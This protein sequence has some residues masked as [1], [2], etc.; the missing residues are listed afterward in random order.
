MSEIDEWDKNQLLNLEKEALGF[1]ITGHP[2][3]G[4]EDLLEKFTNADTLS[5]KERTDRET[6]RIG[7]IIRAI[8]TIK[9][10]KGDL[11]AF[12]T[13]EDLLGAV[14]V[15]VFPSTYTSVCGLLV[16]DSAILIQGQMQKDENAVK[17][18][19]DS[20]IAMDK[21]EENWTA[22]VHFNLNLERT[23]RGILE[24]LHDIL[25]RHP[26]SCQAFIHLREDENNE[27]V[28]ELPDSLTVK[29]GVA[30]TCDVQELL[31]YPAVETVCS[32][33]PAEPAPNNS[34]TNHNRRNAQYA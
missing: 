3:T 14:E 23:E 20:I 24:K 16:D 4:Y 15:T 13:V 29:A 27:V 25:K 22:V 17:I 18:L 1:Y 31:G 28:I 2:L 19:A 6:V 30:L 10:K 33:V 26:G 34:R 32:P 12:V 11:M 5:L 9:T 8:K 21:A 7:G